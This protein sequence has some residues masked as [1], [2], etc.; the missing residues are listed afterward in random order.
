M[1]DF[2]FNSRRTLPVLP[3]RGLSVFPG[4]LLNFDV[5]RPM[6]VA[7]L[8]F[9]MGA[10]QVIFLTA[11]KEISKD[12]PFLDDIYRVGT[13]CRVRQMLRQPG[14]KTVRVMV[15]GAARGRI[16]SVTR[17]APCV[18]AESEPMPDVS[19][20][21][22]VK[23]EALC[24][25]CTALYGEYA[26]I[27]GSV[28]PESVINIMTSTDAAY[29]SDFI[30]QNIYLKP[31]EKQSLLEELRPSRRLS[32]LCR[33]LTRE[34]SLLS[35]ERELNESTQEAMNRN[36]REYFLREQMKIIQSELG[37]DDTPQELDDYR[38]RILATGFDDE[39][40]EK[41]LKEVS[42]LSRQPYGSAE[43]SV[44]RSYLDTCLDVPW[45]IR[46]KETIDIKK[47]RKMLDEDHFGLDKVK[48]RIIEF[49]SVRKLA[50][51]VKGGV[52]C[53]VGPPGTGKT[54][55]AMSI[56]RATNRKLSRVALGGVHDEAEIRGHR[57]TYIGAMP[58]RLVSGLIQA[59][60]MNPLMVLDEIDKLGSDY[61]GD[62]SAAL[63]EALDFE[64]NCHFRDNY[65]EIPVDLSDV[66][67]ITTA[68]TT[69]TIPRP[70]LD[71]MEVIELTSYTDEEKLQIARRHLLPKQREKHGL[72]GRTLRISDDAIREIISLY[73]RESGV[74]LLE[75][76]IAAVCRKCAAGIAQGEYKSLNVRAGML[77]PLLGVP[78][79]KPDAI[80]PRDE[81]GLVRGLAWTAVGGEV[82]DVEVNVVDGA[83]HLELTGNL[84]DVM[85][86]SCKAAISYIR[87]RAS[88]LG[89]DPEF[90]RKKDIHIHFP[91]GA[92]PK[93]GPSAGITIC[94]GVISA[95]TGIPVRRDLAMTGEITLR[96]RILPIGG[97]KEKTMAAL[98]AGVSTV[99]IPAGNEAD[100]DEIDQSVRHSL[101]FVTADHVDAILDTALNRL[102]AREDAQSERQ[103]RTAAT[104][105]VPQP[106]PD[107]GARIGQ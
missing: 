26:E 83:G 36:Q 91:E 50:P 20:K 88:Q 60:S 67:F 51:E 62:P 55:I 49:L 9:A 31:W 56:A 70:L 96:G 103:E 21:T 84:G 69:D 85:K 37:E 104:A 48:E 52:I 6:S 107:A 81:V 47:A 86:E 101:R 39:T 99:I 43:G 61:R 45:N 17:D 76:E 90:Y 79:Y 71:R 92:V 1:S 24:R 35:I 30:A 32:A 65:M 82:L 80:Y 75:R 18:F 95:L 105:P 77:E 19:E 11:Q 94:I 33:M 64:Q 97:L 63:L 93:D 23:T 29:V 16:E 27:S 74:R 68:N 34:L 54:S 4:M 14:G 73:T 22:T 8:N 46:T 15:E 41:L 53:L 44:I 102:A 25:R 78:R 106:V 13:V 98:R 2:E 87:S 7:A 89:I 42:R 40:E 3:L 57:K 66:L 28:A 38:G 5:E 12:V 59:G 100:L 58:G 10:D 72:N